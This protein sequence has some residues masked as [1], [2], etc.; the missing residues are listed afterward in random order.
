MMEYLK[1]NYHLILLIIFMSLMMYLHR[2]ICLTGDDFIYGIYVKSDVATFFNKHISHYKLVN[3]RAIVHFLVTIMLIFD[4]DLWQIINPIA[5]AIFIV[6]VSKISNKNNKSLILTIVL[7]SFISINITRESVF[8]LDGSFNYFYPMIFSLLNIYLFNKIIN[9]NKKY[10]WLPIIGFISGA[11]VEQAGLMTIGV[12]FLMILDKVVINKEKVSR[13]VYINFFVTLIGYLTVILSPGN[14]VRASNNPVNIFYN[15]I[16]LL[17]INFMSDGMQIFIMLLMVSSILWLMYFFKN[18]N[19]IL[20]KTL[21]ILMWINL[22]VYSLI[23]CFTEYITIVANKLIDSNIIVTSSIYELTSLILKF[24]YEI[25]TNNLFGAII[26]GILVISSIFTVVVLIYISIKLY[27]ER[28]QVTFITF[29]IV[30]IGAQLMMVIS[31]VFGFRTVFPSLTALFVIIVFTFI[32]NIENKYTLSL[33]F[34]VVTLATNNI[35]LFIISLLISFINIK[36]YR[37]LD[38]LCKVISI[39]SIMIIT[40]FVINNNIIGYKENYIINEYNLNL[41]KNYKNNGQKGDLILKKS[42]NEKYGYLTIYESEYH[43]KYFKIYYDL[44][45]ETNIVFE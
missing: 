8:W 45:E 39:L 19:K 35:Y 3:G 41:I 15:I 21:L 26:W 9:E 12:M 13:I 29:L 5:I 17:R 28:N 2:F 42:S 1:K 44:S 20:D 14:R 31:P 32:E 27:I 37:Q 34:I 16:E 38:K 22:I 36:D 30:A 10:L 24:I 4:R 18:N 33:L 40:L 25:N 11:T 7:F 43:I 6:L 23:A